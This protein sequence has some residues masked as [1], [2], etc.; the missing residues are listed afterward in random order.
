MAINAYIS[1]IVSK[2]KTKQAEQKQNHRY[3]QHVDGFK[4]GRGIRGIGKKDEINKYKLLATE[5]PWGC[6]DQH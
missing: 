3:R 4:M 6:K 1:T 2:K 5:L